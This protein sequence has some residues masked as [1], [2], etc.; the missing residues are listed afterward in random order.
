MSELREQIDA[1]ICQVEANRADID[2]LQRQADASRER[3]DAAEK[4]ADAADARALIDRDM[5]AELQR[6]GI[7]GQEHAAQLEE[8]LRSSR[9]IGAAIGM[10]MGSRNISEAE[11]FGVLKAASQGSN[12]KLRD[13]A[14]DLLATAATAS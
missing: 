14:S 7:L 9:T 10:I 5:I 8:A 13:I 3:A 11:A 2:A 4:R 12:R 6:D 1:L